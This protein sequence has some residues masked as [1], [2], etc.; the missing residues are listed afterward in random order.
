MDGRGS[1]QLSNAQ[2]GSMM[3]CWPWAAKVDTPTPSTCTK[4]I[5]LDDHHL[6][7]HLTTARAVAMER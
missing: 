5:T 1:P 7:L 4:A 2:R 3:G 6:T